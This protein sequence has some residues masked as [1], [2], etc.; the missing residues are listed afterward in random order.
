M[1]CVRLLFSLLVEEVGMYIDIV[2]YVQRY[3]RTVDYSWKLIVAML[4]PSGYL[5]QR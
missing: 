4:A 1:N 5:E 2:T 3:V